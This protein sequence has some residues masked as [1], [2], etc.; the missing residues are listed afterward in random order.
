M[1]RSVSLFWG[2]SLP[3]LGC[4]YLDANSNWL[5][6]TCSCLPFDLLKIEPEV[7]GTW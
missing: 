6:M 4:K 2:L 7:A 5:I 1:I 3:V